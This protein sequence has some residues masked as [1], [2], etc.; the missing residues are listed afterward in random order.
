MPFKFVE[1]LVVFLNKIFIIIRGKTGV[2][3]D[4]LTLLNS[5]EEIEK[6]DQE[7]DN[8]PLLERYTISHAMACSCR[9]I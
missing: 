9:S 4:T 2:K 1:K 5:N 8:F 6:K 3:N 7:L